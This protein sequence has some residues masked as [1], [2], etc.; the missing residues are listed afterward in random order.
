VL[1]KCE[2]G[3]PQGLWRR[4]VTAGLLEN[5]DKKTFTR[6]A[7]HAWFRMKQRANLAARFRSRGVRDDSS[8]IF[9]EEIGLEQLRQKATNLGVATA[10]IDHASGSPSTTDTE[11]QMQSERERETLFE[12][13]R[14]RELRQ[15]ITAMKGADDWDRWY[16]GNG[17]KQGA[18]RLHF[19]TTDMLAK[20]GLNMEDKELLHRTMSRLLSGSTNT[21]ISCDGATGTAGTDEGGVGPITS[22]LCVDLDDDAAVDFK[23]YLVSTCQCAVA[24]VGTSV[25]RTGCAQPASPWMPV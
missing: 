12:L 4:A 7:S 5:A 14:V 24:A 22:C 20:Y 9:M 6:R 21:S 23:H 17:G 1:W 19:H 25:N 18:E 10:A 3:G 8:S 2:L 11:M 16:N 15:K 13:I